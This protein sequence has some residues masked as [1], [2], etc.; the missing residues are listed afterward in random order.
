M[1]CHLPV[2]LSFAETIL[3]ELSVVIV[4]STSEIRLAEVLLMAEI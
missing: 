3:T 4:T 1:L 2:V